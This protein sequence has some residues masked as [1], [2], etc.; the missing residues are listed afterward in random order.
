MNLELN[1]RQEKRHFY[2]LVASLV[3][4]MALQNLINVGVTSADV[5]MLGK[6]GETALS[7]S[8][9]AGQVLFVMTLV[10][11]GLTSGAAVLTAQYWGKKDIGAI[12]RVLGFSMKIA[13]IVSVLFMAA[14][15]AFPGP[16]MHIF[17][18]EEK[19]VA[20]GISYLRI[21]AFS[22]VF[23]GITVVYLN[24]MRSVERVI[25]STVVYSMSLV[26][27][28]VLNGVFIFG[29]FGL[30]AM[31]IRGAA[32][33]TLIARIAE[34]VVVLIYSKKI[35]RQVCF[36]MKYLFG[37]DQLLV[38]DFFVYALPVLVN[39]LLWGLG[40]STVTAV[41]GHLGSTVVA[42]NSVAQVMR[43][44]A[45]VVSFGVA[46]ATAIMIGKVIGEGK[47]EYAKAYGGR[48]VRLS[49]CVGVAGAGVVLLISP[50]VRSFLT[51]T[52]QAKEYLRLMMFVMAYYIISQSFNTT[53]IVG[54]FR[55]G[56]DTRF[57][58]LVDAATLWCVAIPFGALAA[59]V[60]KLPPIPVYMILTCDELLKI[61]MGIWR[62][63]SY[64]WIQN[65]TR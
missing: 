31:G 41:I 52:P 14:A 8:S 22:Y 4:P 51:L 39:E 28:I 58:L 64:K 23:I 19:V 17:T 16:I 47:P 54:V 29:L 9:L 61:P 30:P 32:L 5:I 59:F 63:R 27:N 48:F 40:I 7:A 6:V 56:G 15:L 3:L 43:Q 49:I 53:M 1:S 44:L 36:R 55:G 37:T 34:F 33:A 50:L 2:K 57:G 65:V 26:I 35:N 45:L 12:E 13:L 18:S 11:F 25:I 24:I 42:A 62:Y 46:N 60:W 21:V 38:K 10:F 20:E